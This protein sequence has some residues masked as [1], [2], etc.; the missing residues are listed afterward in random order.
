MITTLALSFQ[1]LIIL[2]II[3]G[4]PALLVYFLVKSRQQDKKLILNGE[5]SNIGAKNTSSSLDEPTRQKLEKFGKM[6]EKTNLILFILTFIFLALFTTLYTINS[7]SILEV[8]DGAYLVGA[9]LAG[10]T[11][12]LF[13]ISIFTLMF[14]PIR[15]LYKRYLMYNQGSIDEYTF[16]KFKSRSKIWTI[17]LSII[18]IPLSFGIFGLLMI[19]HYIFSSTLNKVKFYD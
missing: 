7:R 15:K 2:I 9:I 18:C 14:N 10:L 4:I 5:I 17:I 16:N 1:H 13:Y 6:S 3:L 11:T 8:T 19:P 12:F